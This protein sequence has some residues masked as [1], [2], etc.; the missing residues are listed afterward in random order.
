[1]PETKS[2]IDFVISFSGAIF[3]AVGLFLLMRWIKLPDAV[4]DLQEAVH[5]IKK[6]ISWM[7][8]QRGGSNGR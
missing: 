1:M 3:S 6:D 4:R 7:K 8:K 2:A 5:L